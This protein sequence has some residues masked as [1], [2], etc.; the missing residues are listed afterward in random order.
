MEASQNPPG[1]LARLCGTRY[2]SSPEDMYMRLICI[3]AATLLWTTAASAHHLW[4]EPDGQGAKL[5]FGEFDENLREAL[6]RS[7]R[8][9]QAAARGEGDR[10]VRPVAQGREDPACLRGERHDRER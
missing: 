6:A 10:H 2:M 8:P 4:L 7:A 9:V 1:G 5:Y 3:F